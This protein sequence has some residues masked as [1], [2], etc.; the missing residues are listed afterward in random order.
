MPTDSGKQPVA[1][2]RRTS[3][4]GLTSFSER[5]GHEGRELDELAAD[6]TESTRAALLQA[7]GQIRRA[8]LHLRPTLAVA[9]PLV[10]TKGGLSSSQMRRTLACIRA[11]IETFPERPVAERRAPRPVP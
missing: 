8:P 9:I 3:D 2:E 11:L 7:L 10:L 4:H 6:L 5:F 1:S